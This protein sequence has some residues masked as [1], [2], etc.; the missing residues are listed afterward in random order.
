MDLVPRWIHWKNGS[1][2]AWCDGA[3]PRISP[4]ADNDH[5]RNS[6]SYILHCGYIHR[7]SILPLGQT[8]THPGLIAIIIVILA[9]TE[10]ILLYRIPSVHLAP[11]SHPPI[12]FHLPL[13][14]TDLVI[15]QAFITLTNAI[16][17]TVLLLKDQFD[18]EVPACTLS[19]R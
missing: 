17:A 7:D 10:G 8:H 1:H 9:I 11:T 13:A 12:P 14:F 18:E 19:E 2:A 5:V 16:L 4:S 3:W 15:S 6:G